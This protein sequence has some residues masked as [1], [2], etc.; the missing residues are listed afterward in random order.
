MTGHRAPESGHKREN[1]R[2]G[3]HVRQRLS[4][5]VSEA[6]MDVENEKPQTD[7]LLA[8][9]GT[10]LARKPHPKI[11]LASPFWCGQDGGVLLIDV[12]V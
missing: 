7:D 5:E 6:G 12:E 1:G 8:D 9:G 4:A 2:R 3:H 11:G 10:L